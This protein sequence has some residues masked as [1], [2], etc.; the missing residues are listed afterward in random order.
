VP[1]GKM[2][3]RLAHLRVLLL[4]VPGVIKLLRASRLTLV[5]TDLSGNSNYTS[6]F[7]QLK[8]LRHGPVKLSVN[9][10]WAIGMGDLNISPTNY[11]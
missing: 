3:K 2:L 6:T 9:Y 1:R 8:V 7:E 4:M 5:N 11:P 10:F